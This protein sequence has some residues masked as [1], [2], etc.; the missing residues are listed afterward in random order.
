MK[1]RRPKEKGRV[2]PVAKYM[3][4]LRRPQRMTDKRAKANKEACRKRDDDRIY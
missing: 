4:L 1:K 3:N 2:N